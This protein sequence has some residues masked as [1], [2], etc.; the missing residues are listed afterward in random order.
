MMVEMSHG[1]EQRHLRQLVL[2]A[3]HGGEVILDVPGPDEPPD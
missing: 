3:S 1:G 2:I